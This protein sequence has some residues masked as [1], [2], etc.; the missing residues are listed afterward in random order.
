MGDAVDN[1]GDLVFDVG[2]SHGTL[3]AGNVGAMTNNINPDTGQCEGIA[4]TAW[5][6]KLMPIRIFNAEGWGFGSDAASGIIYT[7][8]MGANIINA[9]WG[10]PVTDDPEVREAIQIIAEAIQYA[11]SKGVIVVAAAGNSG[12]SGTGTTGLDF[13]AIMKE[14]ISVGSSIG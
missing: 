2:V 3:A 11:V 14:T 12:S 7:A 6:C 9:S 10:A 13:P 8:N 4:G 1:N 5:N